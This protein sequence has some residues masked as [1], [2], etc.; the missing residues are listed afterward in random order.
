MTDVFPRLSNSPLVLASASATRAGMLRSAG[1]E[2][3][4]VPSMID[5]QAVIE[6]MA[7]SR[8]PMSP[9]DISAVLA[10][11]KAED[12]ERR[13]SGDLVLGA[14]QTLEFEGRLFSKPGSVEEARRNLLSLR[15]KTH[16]LHAS[17]ALVQNGQ[18]IWQHTETAW[19][20]MRDFSPRFL[21]RYMAAAGDSVLESV[22]CY[23]LE[24]LGVQLFEHIEGDWFA[25]LGL[26]LMPLLE[27]LRRREVVGS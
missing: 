22:G 12:V 2:I 7:S 9:A 20:T 14:D 18:T 4:V 21:G 3:E 8:E 16:A 24:G 11:A 23:R 10:R 17:A 1:L 27:E 25:I 15:N 19:L 6:A 13:R 26:P 5:E